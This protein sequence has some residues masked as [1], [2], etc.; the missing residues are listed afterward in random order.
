MSM[1]EIRAD[2]AM[3][4]IGYIAS[5]PQDPKAG[6]RARAAFDHLTTWA[7]KDFKLVSPEKAFR[8]HV[9][10]LARGDVSLD[11]PDLVDPDLVAEIDA[12]RVA[13]NQVAIAKSAAASAASAEKRLANMPDAAQAYAQTAAEIRGASGKLGRKMT[14]LAEAIHE[15]QPSA[16]DY[17]VAEAEAM[18]ALMTTMAIKF[19]SQQGAKK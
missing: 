19:K 15:V 7:A 8:L 10:R 4:A 2:L 16:I 11:R 3:S 12:A 6:A 9:A 5:R 1:T 13:A 18:A 14:Y 17:L